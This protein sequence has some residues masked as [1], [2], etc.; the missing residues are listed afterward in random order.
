MIIW[1]NESS[2]DVEHKNGFHFIIHPTDELPGD[3]SI[4]FYQPDLL[5]NYIYVQP[6]KTLIS[7]DLKAASVKRRNC[8]FDHEKKLEIFRNYTR[9]NCEHECKRSA[10]LERCSCVPFYLLSKFCEFHEIQELNKRFI[11]TEREQEKIC[12]AKEHECT[13][14]VLPY[15]N[16]AIRNCS[17]L[18]RCEAVSYNVVLHQFSMWVYKF[19]SPLISK[20]FL[21]R[22]YENGF[23]I[24]FARNFFL[25][26]VK[27]ESLVFSDFLSNVGGMMGLFAGVSVLS[28]IEL[29]FFI[30]RSF[31]YTPHQVVPLS[32]VSIRQRAAWRNENHAL[33]QLSKYF[34]KYVKVSD[35]HGL[36]YTREKSLG[37][38]GRIFWVL[39]ILLSISICI[40]LVFDSIK[41]SEKSPVTV[42]IDSRMLSYDDVRNM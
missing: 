1:P 11:E 21:L 27:V 6:D 37:R 34:V 20:T 39:F 23:V 26:F 22:V 13:R 19:F 41:H 29:L 18:E 3:S 42:K 17:C 9:S 10:F 31:C 7:S 25:P 4:H 5:L 15:L 38:I 14:D 2:V 8:Y 12:D 33:Y 16:Q 32:R 24:R 35:M 36:H 28:V 30:I 40:F